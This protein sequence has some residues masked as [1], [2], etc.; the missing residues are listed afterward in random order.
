MFIIIATITIT[1]IIISYVKNLFLRITTFVLKFPS[2]IQ[3]EK[4]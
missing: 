2:Q 1:I 3:I 4:L